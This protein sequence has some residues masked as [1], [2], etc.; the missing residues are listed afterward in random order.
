[1]IPLNK[2]NI[3]QTKSKKPKINIAF[4]NYISSF[5]QIQRNQ[6]PSNIQNTRY[7]HQNTPIIYHTNTNI[8]SNLNSK[9]IK[10]IDIKNIPNEILFKNKKNR[11]QRNKIKN[12]IPIKTTSSYSYENISDNSMPKYQNNSFTQRTIETYEI[13][14]GKNYCLNNKYFNRIKD[15]ENNSMDITYYKPIIYINKNENNNSFCKKSENSEFFTQNNSFFMNGINLEENFNPTNIN[16]NNTINYNKEKYYKHK[17][18]LSTINSIPKPQKFRKK[19]PP[20]PIRKINESNNI[21]FYFDENEIN[22]N[23]NINTNTI[24]NSHKM[25]SGLSTDKNKLDSTNLNTFTKKKQKNKNK[26]YS[27]KT[28]SIGYIK[29]IEKIGIQLSFSSNKLR[30]ESIDLISPE[31]LK[32]LKQYSSEKPN[33]E[34]IYSDLDENKIKE[35][36]HNEKIKNVKIFN[37]QEDYEKNR[38]K[39]YNKLSC[40]L[41]RNKK[42]KISY[43]NTKKD[44]YDII[45]IKEKIKEEKRNRSLSN[46]FKYKKKEIIKDSPSATNIKKRDDIGGKID[47]KVQSIKAKRYCIKKGIKRRIILNDL[48]KQCKITKSP[49]DKGEIII[50]AAKTI[51]KWWRDLISKIY[52]ILHVIKIQSVFRSFL[53][54]K[55]ILQRK[56]NKYLTSSQK[57]YNFIYKKIINKTQAINNSINNSN[58]QRSRNMKNNKISNIISNNSFKIVSNEELNSSIISNA[59]EA[60]NNLVLI[61]KRNLKLCLFTKKYY[62]NPDEKKIRF[63]QRYFKNYL[64][65]INYFKYQ[66]IMKYPLIP[67]SLIEKIRYKNINSNTPLNINPINKICLFTKNNI[68]FKKK[69]PIVF[70]VTKMNYES[71]ATKN[72]IKKEIIL[73]VDN[74]NPKYEIIQN[75]ENQFE[76]LENIYKIPNL[77]NLCYIDK[78]FI[79]DS[80][81]NNEKIKIIQNKFRQMVNKR[82]KEIQKVY[83]NP[84]TLN[85]YISKEFKDNFIN[86]DK[87]YLIQKIVRKFIEKVKE[88]K[89]KQNL[90]KVDNINKNIQYYENIEEF[91]NNIIKKHFI[92]YFFDNIRNNFKISKEK[93]F[94]KMLTQRIKKIINQFVYGKLKSDDINKIKQ[95]K[96]INKIENQNSNEINNNNIILLNDESNTENKIF[97]FNTI[98]RQI[99]INEIDNKLDDNNE[100]VK[101]L[102]ESIP[103][104]FDNYPKMKYIPYIKKK[105]EKNLV[106]QQIFL[107]D[108]DSLANYIYKCYQIEKNISTI[109]PDIIKKRLILEPMKNQNIFTITRYMDNLYNDYMKN[110]VCKNCY[111][112]NSELCLSGC[113]CHNFNNLKLQSHLKNLKNKD[114]NIDY[115]DE[116]L[117]INLTINEESSHRNSKTLIN[118]KKQ[119]FNDINS[120]NT[121]LT[122]IKKSNTFTKDQIN[123]NNEN[124]EL[125]SINTDYNNKNQNHKRINNFIRNFALRKKLRNSTKN[126]LSNINHQNEEIETINF[127]FNL[128]NNFNDKS[129]EKIDLSFEDDQSNVYEDD[130]KIENSIKKINKSLLKK[131]MKTIAP[132]PNHI[133]NIMRMATNFRNKQ[134]KERRKKKE[135]IKLRDSF[136]NFDYEYYE[137]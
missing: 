12:N 66:K 118:T 91:I 137:K 28:Y 98:K 50:N 1:M 62:Q 115:S 85:T 123:I 3:K 77:K 102:K 35:F 8:S 96:I 74:K 130:I 53:M 104:Y 83:K 113:K 6:T 120:I 101:L 132:I 133:R 15:R 55:K 125:N 45:D 93:Y 87:I 49:I 84:I 82:K 128:N 105:N 116:N 38:K 103:D 71:I 48:I 30:N 70:S 60:I 68:F 114:N 73:E 64:N 27:N 107:F 121:N 65:N 81:Q 13:P 122:D 99:K 29:N 88:E 39:K 21:S 94:I 51:Q 90:D 22:N 75:F 72:N 135:V 17:N 57:K 10:E 43:K 58:N 44:K 134:N 19:I 36:K 31:V 16:L 14:L 2:R 76:I 112:K 26:K 59:K 95:K 24:P 111:C 67:L 9:D 110:K 119:E 86:S 61:D 5:N 11:H 42:R 108:D 129:S 124:D 7:L 79:N 37:I 109:T 126:N 46:L 41:L 136:V 25:K 34:I 18:S 92:N 23:I 117:N 69:K 89:S 52:I 63:L 47:L 54:R 32:N 40:Y 106:N 100:I 80:E 127:N 4:E 131:K 20:I 56:N 33:K 78:V 97:F